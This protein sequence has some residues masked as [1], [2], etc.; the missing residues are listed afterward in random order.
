MSLDPPRRSFSEKPK[1]SKFKDI[2]AVARA[3]QLR[4]LVWSLLLGG[5]LGGAVG[6]GIGH[7]FLGV[8]L[9]PVAMYTVIMGVANFAGKGAGVLYMPSGSTTPR[10]KEYSRAMALEVRGEFEAAV[11]A[12]EEAIL[13]APEMGE[14]YL[15][16]ARLFR[17][18]LKETELA[19]RWFRRAQREA[20]LSSGETIRTH[21]ELAEI[22]LHVRRE[23][24]RAAPELARLAS[25]FPNTSDGEWAT[26]ELA[27]IKD[28]MAKERE[29]ERA[30]P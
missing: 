30:E 4:G 3:Q 12:Y 20:K 28:E 17:D 2:D 16:I 5:P 10:K 27:E 15:R 11:Q 6:A 7:P 13:D 23:P 18:Q 29:E 8:L 25:L 9:G 22:F 24:K 1:N 19:V 21:R 14:P 26:K